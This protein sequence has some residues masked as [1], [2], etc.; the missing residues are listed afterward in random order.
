MNPP[1]RSNSYQ[2]YILRC[3]EERS[4][5][6]D[7]PGVWRFSL[8]DVRTG[9]LMGFATLEAMVTYVQNKLAPTNK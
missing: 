4:T 1:N 8:E 6:Q 9:R 7:Q 2:S 5:Q 3:W